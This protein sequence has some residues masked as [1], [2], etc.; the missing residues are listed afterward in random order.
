MDKLLPAGGAPF[1]L[2]TILCIAICVVV[3]RMDAAVLAHQW[4]QS[5]T[6]AHCLFVAPAAAV[7]VF[8]QRQHLSRVGF[9]PSLWG[10]S[11][12]AAASA[13]WWIGWAAD[14]NEVRQLSLVALVPGLVLA[15]LGRRACWTLLYP[16]L[17]LFLMV[18]T[19]EIL[20]RPLTRAT[21]GLATAMLS[22]GNVPMRVDGSLIVV[23]LRD[24]DIGPACAGLNFL[25]AT[26]VLAPL[27]AAIVFRPWWKRLAAITVAVALSILTNGV[28][29]YGIIALA[30]ASDGRID[31]GPDHLLVGWLLFEVVMA[32]AMML[33]LRFR[34]APCPPPAEAADSH[35]SWRASAAI[36]L[37]AMVPALT[38]VTAMPVPSAPPPM[39]APALAAEIAGWR[40]EASEDG[41]RAYGKDGLRIDLR[42]GRR[43][44]D[45]LASA[46]GQWRI[47]RRWHP[48]VELG[49]ERQQV[50]A[51]LL[52][53]NGSRR[54]AWVWYQAGGSVTGDSLGARLRDLASGIHG[55]HWPAAVVAATS[56]EDMDAAAAALADFAGRR[57]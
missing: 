8:Q 22:A 50:T 20:V 39:V 19:G 21:V 49:G 51:L 16:L 44:P 52:T 40:Q 56:G 53:R 6:Y 10:L 47:E 48:S 9:R 18:P 7:L 37:L 45:G 33:G 3:F 41:L 34:D 17:Y 24:Y 14:I 35:G 46:E 31:F 4:T 28:R 32:A 23:P 2:T 12:T 42:W 57:L 38:T 29:V 55:G 1:V 54:L 13:V 5:L 11:A 27:Y 15:V 30:E 26:L 43:D 25:F 36:G